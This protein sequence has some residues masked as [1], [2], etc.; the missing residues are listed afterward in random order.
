MVKKERKEEW[1]EEEE[2]K[3]VILADSFNNRFRPISYDIPR[4]LIPL[5]NSPLIEY[6][7]EFLSSAGIKEVFVFC[8]SHADKITDYLGESRWESRASPTK[9][10]VVE[11]P[12]AINNGDILR[13]IFNKSIF[14]S[15]FVLVTSDVLSNLQFGDVVRA[16][17]ARGKADKRNVMTVV[18]KER[19]P[20]H[21]TRSKEDS[22][23][24]ALEPK[25]GEVLEYRPQGWRTR[26]G[27]T[28]PLELFEKSSQVDVRADLVDCHIYICSPQVPALFSDNFDYQ[29]VPNFI[30]GLLDDDVRGDHV[31][32]HIIQN[33]YASRVI[34]P[35][36]YDA[37]S[38]EVIQRWTFPLVPDCN[39]LGAT[40]YTYQRRNIYV[41][42]D[43]TLTRTCEVQENTI[44][45]TG[46]VI[47]ARTV[48]RNSVIG[49]QCR[50]GA[51]CVIDGCYIWDD[52]TIGDGCT[53]TKGIICNRVVVEAGVT[54][55]A[56]A[57]V[58][59]DVVIGAGHTVPEG[60]KLTLHS[61]D[62]GFSDDEEDEAVHD[63]AVVGRGGQGHLW[64]PE[65]DDSDV[66]DLT[67]VKAGTV[68][69]EET[70]SDGS[71][72]D[73]DDE[74]MGY[75]PGVDPEQAFL[76]EVK[77]SLKRAVAEKIDPE[78]IVLEINAS[79]HAYNIPPREVTEMVLESILDLSKDAPDAKAL[80]TQL[81]KNIHALKGILANYVKS[82]ADELV[83]V[84]SLEEYCLANPAF[85]T[86]M[87][88]LLQIMYKEELLEEDA[89]FKWFNRAGLND[90]Q[91]AIR[92]SVKAFITWLEEA[93]EESEDED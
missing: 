20:Q 38:K 80:G 47:G 22:L 86:M 49:S 19:H 72:D 45:G 84:E 76:M 50:I 15:D 40:N 11:C 13:E 68:E 2:L 69:E 8:C 70:E 6:T 77:D 92:K 28:F 41:D 67:P 52:V 88:R 30:R 36:M 5:A 14:R 74:D 39:L 54:I 16:H 29:D 4:A 56:G 1:T 7:L 78:N 82:G 83:V 3:A 73:E 37:I 53:L 17:R 25:T 87:Q 23:V 75:Q 48:V 91:K 9:V 12:Q 79:K 44:I 43:V 71:F 64:Q 32:S 66:E 89:I 10:H 63:E 21:K 24:V 85:E 33:D 51:N 59:F 65:S 42:D 62:D 57:I 81:A 55:N 46:T 34:N 60:A 31:H 93:E 27:R 18:F 26:L 61:A 35:K 90:R 58:S